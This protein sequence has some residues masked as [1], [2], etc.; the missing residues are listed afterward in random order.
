M[1]LLPGDVPSRQGIQDAIDEVRTDVMNILN[2]MDSGWQ[3]LTLLSPWTG[4]AMYRVINNVVYLNGNVSRPSGTNTDIASLPELIRPT[5]SHSAV[6]RL[7]SPFG[8]VPFA[9]SSADRVMRISNAQYTNGGVLALS[10]V[11]PYP[12][13]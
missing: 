11:A 13:G 4:S 1:P 2:N 8:M 3:T 7:N 10:S 5:Y 9:V 6:I 12:L